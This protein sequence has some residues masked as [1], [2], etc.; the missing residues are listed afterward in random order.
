MATAADVSD[1][2]ATS[3]HPVT[4]RFADG[5]LEAAFLADWNRRALLPVRA[6]TV[7]GIVMYAMFAAVD[8]AV[9]PDYLPVTWA[10]RFALVIPLAI[11]FFALSFTG[12]FLRHLQVLTAA[13]GTAGG[14][15]LVVIIT[16]TGERG[17][18]YYHA[19]ILLI[20][21][22]IGMFTRLRFLPACAAIAIVVAT[23]TVILVGLSG[24]PAVAVL[25]DLAF[26]VAVVFISLAAAYAFERTSRE[27]FFR[28]RVIEE[29]AANLA[30]A[31]A[32]VRE[33]S[34]LIPI[35][36]WCKKVRDDDGYWQ[37]L[38]SYLAPRSRAQ[39]SHG[40]CPDCF[41]ATQ[42]EA[43]GLRTDPQGG[44]TVPG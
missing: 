44:G 26:V 21:A 8:V 25:N 2:T 7:L 27:D 34:G 6:A 24:Q 42:D 13:L 33:L 3:I 39:F 15:G 10:I 16:V 1:R 43:L 41:A 31:L 37:K 32:N 20:A 40:M 35:C 22:Y 4:L 17:Q 18:L 12:W 23:D 30:D 29:Q 9:V 28:R 11:L 38:E 19:G 5:D 36:A 14:L